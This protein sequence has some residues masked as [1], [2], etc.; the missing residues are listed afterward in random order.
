[1][2]ASTVNP[3]PTLEED[4]RELDRLLYDSIGAARDYYRQVAARHGDAPE[5]A[6]WERLFAPAEVKVRHGS[7]PRSL[8]RDYEWIHA[9]A[10]DYWGEWLALYDGV[11]IAHGPDSGDVIDRARR[12]S[13]A[14]DFLLFFAGRY[15]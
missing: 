5:L 14:P 4:L 2:S 7:P 6:R 9:H 3:A 11:L 1:M 15:S 13:P 8:D 10:R 12:A